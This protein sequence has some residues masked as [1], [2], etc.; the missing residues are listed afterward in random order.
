M[1]GKKRGLL[2]KIKMSEGV[3]E[4]LSDRGI[5][6]LSFYVTEELWLLC[7]HQGIPASYQ[8]QLL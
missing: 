1:P 2:G 4:M 8:H 7:E 5:L 3:P 6:I